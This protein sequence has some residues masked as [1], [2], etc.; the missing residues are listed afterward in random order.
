ME[1]LVNASHLEDRVSLPFLEVVD[2][3]FAVDLHVAHLLIDLI[4]VS[5]QQLLFLLQ[6]LLLSSRCD[7]SHLQKC[8]LLCK[9]DQLLRRL[10]ACFLLKLLNQG[11]QPLCLLPLGLKLLLVILRFGSE[12]LLKLLA[13]LFESDIVFVEMVLHHDVPLDAA[14]ELVDLA[15]LSLHDVILLVDLLEALEKLELEEGILDVLL[16]NALLLSLAASYRE[17]G[18]VYE[19]V[20]RVDRTIRVRNRLWWL[21]AVR[22]HHVA[23]HRTS[24]EGTSSLIHLEAISR[25]NIY[26]ACC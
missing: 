20:P 26:S 17:V 8:V 24:W 1:L 15:F 23:H 4:V 5:S 11:L 12:G 2:P 18:V 10:V 3:D 19:A 7:Q 9:L 22:H 13:L 14:V 25:V 16:V 6:I 21:E